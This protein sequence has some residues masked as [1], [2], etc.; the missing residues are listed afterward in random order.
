MQEPSGGGHIALDTLDLAV[1][2]ANAYGRDD[3]VQRL[4]DARRL[5][6]EPDVTV[7]VVGE[8]K[9]GK[10]SLINALLTAKICPVD[11]DIA[12]AVPTVVRYAPESGALATYEPADPSS[13]PWTERISLED[14]P[15]H[16]AVGFWV[17]SDALQHTGEGFQIAVEDGH[18]G[19][20]VSPNKASDQR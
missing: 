5:L 7:Y 14:L 13:P 16:V 9:Q 6:S 10:S 19:N 1:K 15:Y 8:F 12:T 20:E 4:T 2:G 18:P 11:D 17:C 3:L